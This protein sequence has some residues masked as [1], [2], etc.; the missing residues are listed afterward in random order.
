MKKLGAGLAVVVL[1][2]TSAC[3]GGG[4]PTAEEMS[5]A[6]QKGVNGSSTGGSEV[7]LTKKQA[8][9]AGKVFVESKISDDALRAIVD[10]KKDFKESKADDKALKTV[11]PKLIKCAS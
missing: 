10:G 9:C 11:L 1:L 2:A 5:K 7:K 8:D 3:G 6:F 4:R